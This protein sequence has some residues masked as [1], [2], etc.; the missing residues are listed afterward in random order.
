MR[1]FMSSEIAV[2]PKDFPTLIAFVGFMIGVR[3]QMGLQIGPLVEA[4]HANW[5]LMRRFVHV[6]NLV[7][8]QSAGL[9]KSL[10]ANFAFE[11]FVR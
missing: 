6:K 1:E 7:Y 3:E 8:C 11:W 9:T 2:P 10:A 5:T 4:S